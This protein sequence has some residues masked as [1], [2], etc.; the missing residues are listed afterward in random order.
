MRSIAVGAALLAATALG[1]P[2]WAQTYVGLGLGQSSVNI[3]CTGADS[4]DKRDTAFKVY[5]GYRFAP[6]IGVEAAYYNAGKARL[7]GSDPEVGTLGA[8]LKS[9]GYGLFAVG[10]LP[11]D[12]FSL[13]AKVG[14]AETKVRID[15][16]SSLLGTASANQRHT[17]VAWGLGGD[18][19]ITKS[20]ALRAEY[21]RLRVEL[22]D[23]KDKLSIFSVGLDYSF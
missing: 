21:E 5:G 1:A 20:L 19:R 16:V 15:A 3:D 14:A 6:W 11:L 7:S 18:W 12:R 9:T 17:D 10:M 22:F 23:E 13:F 4:C 2:A 8:D